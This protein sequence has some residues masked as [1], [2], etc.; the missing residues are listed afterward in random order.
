MGKKGDETKNALADALLTILLEGNRSAITVKLVSERAG[1]DRQT[2]YYHFRSME[3]LV[4]Y[5][6]EREA[7]ELAA[8][9]GH[10]ASFDEFVDRVVDQISARKRVFRALLDRFGRPTLRALL[11]ERAI[12]LLR[13]YAHREL[14]DVERQI[15]PR[16]RDEAVEYCVRASASVLEAWITGELDMD[17]ERL[18][19]FLARSF[20]QQMIGVREIKDQSGFNLNP[21]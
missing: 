14:V 7:S 17:G 11:H 18:K 5:L 10:D 6:S 19:S 8:Q 2:F 3:E 20:R 12:G 4:G 15:G 21:V 1:V 13:I 9:I 16:R